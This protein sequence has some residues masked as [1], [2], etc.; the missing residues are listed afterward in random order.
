MI[1][2]ENLGNIVSNMLSRW[3]QNGALL[4]LQIEFIIKCIYATL[5]S[6]KYEVIELRKE[7]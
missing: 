2:L 5:K 1:E 7:Q 4:Q 3:E 6:E